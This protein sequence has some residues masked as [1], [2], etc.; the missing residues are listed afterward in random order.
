LYVASLKVVPP[1][2]DRFLM[3][4]SKRASTSASL[5]WVFLDDEVP[6]AMQCKTLK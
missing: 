2:F 5:Q 4:K 1:S 6:S 3:R